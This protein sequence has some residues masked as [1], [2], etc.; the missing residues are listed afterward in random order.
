MKFLLDNPNLVALF[1]NQHHNFSLNPKVLSIPLGLNGKE[2]WRAIHASIHKRLKK[3]TLLFI[4][5][6]IWAFRPM[7]KDCV[8]DKMKRDYVE[9]G[10]VTPEE[11]KS[12]IISS[13]AVLCLPG[14]GYGMLLVVLYS[15]HVNNFI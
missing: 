10:R 2:T 8:I 4:G 3:E 7:L 1:V 6:S 15:L 9:F 5:T 13:Y 12:K 14:Q 11:F